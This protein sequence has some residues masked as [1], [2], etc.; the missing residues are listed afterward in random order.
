MS[1]M[2]IRLSVL[3]VGASRWSAAP[4]VSGLAV[5]NNPNAEAIAISPATMAAMRV[6]IDPPCPQRAICAALR[7]R[8]SGSESLP[9]P[10]GM[11]Q[12]RVLGEP[13]RYRRR[14]HDDGAYQDLR[15]Q[16]G[17]RS[18]Q[19]AVFSGAVGIGRLP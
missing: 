4:D 17:N 14:G 12:P 16:R 5:S 3:T 7:A 6:R 10:A 2:S 13:P 18:F 19:S 11:A 8:W 1:V 9:S 15:S